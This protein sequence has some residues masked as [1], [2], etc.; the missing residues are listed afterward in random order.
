MASSD[1]DSDVELLRKFVVISDAEDND[2]GGDVVDWTSVAFTGLDVRFDGPG[3]V[4][5][6]PLPS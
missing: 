4:G 5:L 1:G 2:E 6:H 3:Q